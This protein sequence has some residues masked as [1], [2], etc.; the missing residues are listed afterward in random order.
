MSQTFASYPIN[1]AAK[2]TNAF[3]GPLT[4][5]TQW[6]PTQDSPGDAE[7][8]S[9]YISD[10][11]LPSY[12]ELDSLPELKSI[13]SRNAEDINEF[14]RSEG[15][16]IHLDPFSDGEFGTASI[17]KI[18]VE[19]TEEGLPTTIIGRSNK[20]SYPGFIL[21]Q[22]NLIHYRSSEHT[23]PVTLLETKNAQQGEKVYVTMVDR[24]TIGKDVFALST[25]VKKIQNS[26]LDHSY[27]YSDIHIP[28]VDI[29]D[30][31]DISWL[32]GMRRRDQKDR[33]WVI[34]EAIQQTKFRMNAKGA[35]AK[36]I[37][38]MRLECASASISFDKKPPLKINQQFV[39]W[40]ERQGL[41]QPF[42]IGYITEEDWK[43]KGDLEEI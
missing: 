33:E 24:N 29:D 6:E 16:D 9:E 4:P 15:F 37:A 11:F 18:K 21:E 1:G 2:A 28:I 14:A 3:L 40:I 23:Y 12:E 19:W 5:V 38:I 36:S 41:S 27:E 31:P 26:R 8:Q 39:I 35:V 34:A 32:V 25:F 22:K 10:Y 43:D 17:M 42:F 13:A 30:K 20:V 7:L